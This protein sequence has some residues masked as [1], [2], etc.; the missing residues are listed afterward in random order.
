MNKEI[1]EELINYGNM[2][3]EKDLTTGTGGNISYF[4]RNE[5]VMYITPSGINYD[6]IEP[7]DICG[8]TLD[9]EQVLGDRKPS[10]ESNMH[11]EVYRHRDDVN[12]VI[13]CHA[14]YSTVVASTFNELP[15]VSYLVAHSGS[16][17]VKVA[18]YRQFGSLELAKIA[19]ETM[20]RDN[21]VLLENHG[22][23]TVGDSLEQ[24]LVVL[25]QIEFSAKLYVKSK[26]CG[27]PKIISE[28][29]MDE[30]IKAFSNYGQ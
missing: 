15:A 21:A 22:I 4:D 12:S 2:L 13:H 11:L 19:I 30:T 29:S 24:A 5:N 25:E 9:G 7:E 27:N 17:T 1:M 28:D 14:I 23:N 8:L 6:E 18:P 26:S 20:E 10:S 16:N 3:I